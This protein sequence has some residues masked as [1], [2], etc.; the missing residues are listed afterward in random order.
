MQF[1]IW[2]VAER[3]GV[4]KST[5]SRVLNGGSVSESTHQKVMEAI[6]EMGYRPNYNARN[7]R[8]NK[9]TVIGVLSMGG[10]MFREHSLCIRFSGVSDILQQHG[11]DLMLVHDD[12]ESLNG[13]YTPKC[14]TYLS[15]KRI[16]GLITLG[17][18]DQ[19]EEQI[20]S[21]ASVFRNVVYTGERVLKDKGFR[22]YLGNYHYSYDLFSILLE[23]GHRRILV[24]YGDQN[25]TLQKFRKQAFQD[26]C[27][28]LHTPEQDICRFY[29]PYV[30]DRWIVGPAQAMENLYKTYRQGGYTALFVDET[31]DTRQILSTFGRYGMSPMRDYSIVSIEGEIEGSQQG[32]E[33]ITSVHL[34]DYEY[35]RRIAEL[36]TEV[37]E[38]ESLVCK[39]VHM[40][41][42]L[43]RGKSVQKLAP[44]K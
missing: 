29:N 25:N 21:A 40:A 4:S 41:Y 38:N 22:V 19:I 24:I 37:I 44:N 32:M 36:M 13:I 17:T 26:A 31:T 20:K 5:V 30:E 18:T 39:D 16:D 42:T 28:A 7:L 23:Q 15:E 33:I 2:D 27:K 10:A 12:Y 3:A 9:S 6:Q 14:M 11:Y 8:G 34:P 43:V 35:G 1:S